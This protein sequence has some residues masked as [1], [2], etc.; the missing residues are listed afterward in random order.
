MGLGK[1]KNK[2]LEKGVIIGIV[3]G[4]IALILGA[5]FLITNAALANSQDYVAD[6]KFYWSSDGGATYV[7]QTKEY[8]VGENAYMQLIVGVKNPSVFQKEIKVSL[9]IPYV[10]DIESKYMDGQI[11]TPNVDEVNSV[12]TYDFTVISD[13]KGSEQNFVFKF[14]PIKASDI[15]LKLTFDDNVKPLYDKQNT[16]TFVN[17]VVED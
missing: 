14:V 13:S 5:G 11:I 6:A 3:I 1:G 2:G 7:N 12:T 16:V 8:E 10:K 9:E 15:T 17:P 4:G